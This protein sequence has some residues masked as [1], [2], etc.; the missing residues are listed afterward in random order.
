[1]R[2]LQEI[3]GILWTW[4]VSLFSFSE[5]EP[6]Q[7]PET[8]PTVKI[9]PAKG[10][11]PNF[12]PLKVELPAL[13]DETAPLLNYRH[14]SV[15][16][17]PERRLPYYT[18]VNINAE[19]YNQLKEQ[20]PTRKE[21]GDNWVTEPR[22]PKTEQLPESFYDHNDF[23]LGHMVRREDALWGDSVEEAI[24]ANNDTFHL[25]NAVPQHKDFNRNAQ[26]WK[27]LE[28]YALKNARANDLKVSVFSGCVFDENDRTFE[29]VKIP[30]KFWK[31]LVM[32]K[33]NG[34]LSATGYLVQQDDLIRS[35]T[36]REAGFRYEQFKTYQVPISKIE[37]LTGLQFGLNDHDP[38][39][40]MGVRGE[41][42][43]PA[44]I[45]DYSDIVF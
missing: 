35:I 25:T 7:K 5:E 17:N 21:L 8:E 13:D 19:K 1:M 45:D 37:E 39:Q 42:V 9:P 38:M 11:D 14:F 12:L 2:K 40:K 36:E 22:I 23:D 34:E 28:D 30:G 4:L 43:L 41:E 33:L 27:G 16:M 44:A 29:A 32:V 20:L 31:I 6:Q 18:A 26:R 15:K 10:F 3:L 24:A